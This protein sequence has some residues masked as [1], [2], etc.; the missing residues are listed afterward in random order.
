MSVYFRL[1]SCSFVVVADETQ[2]YHCRYKVGDKNADKSHLFDIDVVAV[3]QK[4]ILATKAN[5][6]DCALFVG[7][8]ADYMMC[9]D[10]TRR[11]QKQSFLQTLLWFVILAPKM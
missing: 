1:K 9:F 5:C 8:S 7:C 6:R 3:L 11:K 10:H 4:I 2:F